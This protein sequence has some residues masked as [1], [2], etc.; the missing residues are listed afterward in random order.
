MESRCHVHEESFEASP[1]EMF[2]L[3]VTPSAIRGWWGASQAMVIPEEGGIWAAVWGDEDCPDYITSARILEFDPP[4]RLVMKYEHY[5]AKT[6]VLP[7]T[8]AEDARTVFTVHPGGA[9]SILRVEQT[10]FPLTGLAD[11]FYEACRTGWL[12]TFA[13]IRNH[14][15]KGSGP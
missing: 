12:N 9:G 7:F 1:D 8:F 2:S 15:T 4:S 13:G 10:G 11:D 14:V 6:G 5:H 3:L